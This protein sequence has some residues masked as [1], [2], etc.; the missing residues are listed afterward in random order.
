MTS[1]YESA[2]W[3]HAKEAKVFNTIFASAFD[4]SQLWA[5]CWYSDRDYLSC[6]TEAELVREYLS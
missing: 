6:R 1:N 3:S 5:G 2:D 4:K